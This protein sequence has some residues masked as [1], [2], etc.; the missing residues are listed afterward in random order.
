MSLWLNGEEVWVCPE[1]GT[2]WHDKAIPEHLLQEGWYG[3]WDGVT[4]RYYSRVIGIYDW[5]TDRTVAWRCPDC[6]KEWPR[7]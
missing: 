1:C 6:E 2:D 7:G 4:P 5:N 3:A